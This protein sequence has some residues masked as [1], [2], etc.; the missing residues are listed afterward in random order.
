MVP[1]HLHCGPTKTGNQ[2]PGFR[3]GLDEC[4]M[5]VGNLGRHI[6]QT[7]G[8]KNLQ[9]GAG[10]NYCEPKVSHFM[11]SNAE[12][13]MMIFSPKV[14]TEMLKIE[15]HPLKQKALHKIISKSVSKGFP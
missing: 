9:L 8:H 6:H 3:L 7:I 12:Q 1:S 14:E 15:T 2:R 4:K 11:L 10:D 5:P 13:L